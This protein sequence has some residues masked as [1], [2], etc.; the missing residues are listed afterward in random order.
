M[1]H[2]FKLIRYKNLL[3]IAA[4]QYLMR[5]CIVWPIIR[6]NGFELQLDNLHFFLLVLS[7]MLITAAGY[8][9]ND[10]FDTKTDMLNR[11][12]TVLVGKQISRRTAMF[13]H[14]ML[15]IAGIGLGIYL[16]VKIGI[17]ALGV[18]YI[19]ASGI[20]WFYSTTYKRQFLIGNL[21]VSIFTGVVPFVV[22][23]FEVP[24]LN[25]AYRDIL[26]EYNINFNGLFAWVGGF[27]FFAFLS[28]LV[29]EI[30]KDVE[31]FEGDLAFGRNTLPVILGIKITKLIIIVL[32]L[33][34]IFAI[35]YVYIKY[36]FYTVNG[37][38][39]LITMFY[40]LLFLIVPFFVLAWIIFK[41]DN[42]DDYHR[43]SNITKI[44]MLAGI[45]YSIVVY[46]IIS[47]S[48]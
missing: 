32:I 48:F 31:D 38:Y 18:A 40:L 45:T 33:S 46:F 6:V 28:N 34:N 19:L 20:L 30:I 36:L 44:I 1:I 43:A 9:I 21:I 8:V 16:S 39:D 17:L 27:A 23:L 5:Y 11:P 26:L 24:L 2:F 10:Y 42:K 13:I 4:T 7:S 25:E 47:N 35:S 37:N 22:V 12:S 15:N 29:R 41:A 14:I 3:I